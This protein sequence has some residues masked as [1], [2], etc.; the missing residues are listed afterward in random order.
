MYKTAALGRAK[1]YAL[2]WACTIF[3]ACGSYVYWNISVNEVLGSATLCLALLSTMILWLYYGATARTRHYRRGKGF[4]YY[5]M[6][7]WQIAITDLISALLWAVLCITSVFSSQIIAII[8]GMICF[9]CMFVSWYQRY[10]SEVNQHQQHMD[11]L[12]IIFLKRHKILN[13]NENVIAIYGNPNASSML[14]SPS[15]HGISVLHLFHKPDTLFVALTEHE[16]IIGTQGPLYYFAYTS[17][18][19]SRIHQLA[20]LSDGTVR[21]RKSSYVRGMMLLIGDEHG[22]QCN[23]N[24]PSTTP[25]V[26][27]RFIRELLNQMDEA[28][29]RNGHLTEPIERMHEDYIPFEFASLLVSTL[30]IYQPF[31]R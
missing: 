3:M 21:K 16:C 11:E 27:Q 24:L 26:I 19:Y 25:V 18:P 10:Q 8:G 9:V 14:A 31:T 20:I 5:R 4:M 2:H 30:E 12:L 13:E 29:E 23:V 6:A 15:G 7:N 22:G 28:Q 1:I 17:I